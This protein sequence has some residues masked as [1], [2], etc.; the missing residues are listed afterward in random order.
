MIGKDTQAHDII[1]LFSKEK[2]LVT[3]YD[4]LAGVSQFDIGRLREDLWSQFE[5]L[6]KSSEEQAVNSKFMD[7]KLQRNPELQNLIQ[8]LY[9][10]NRGNESPDLEI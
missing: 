4:Y 10:L 6:Y 3:L 5:Q 8:G 1:K 7:T 2:S 9:S